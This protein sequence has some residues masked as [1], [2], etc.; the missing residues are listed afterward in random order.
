MVRVETRNLWAAGGQHEATAVVHCPVTVQE[1]R[2]LFETKARAHG[3]LTLIGACRSFGEQFL[4]PAG[5]ECVTLEHWDRQV[6]E[7]EQDADG[8]LWVRAPGHLPFHELCA[9]LPGFIPFHPPSGDRI[10]LAG[11]FAACTQDAV[12]PFASKVRAFTLLTPNGE[13]HE[14]RADAPGLA[15]ELFRLVPG[16][17]GALGAILSLELCMRRLK[18]DERAE[19]NVLECGPAA[20]YAALERLEAIF[21]SGEY[22]LGRGLFFYGRKHTSVLL[23]DR[24]RTLPS[25]DRTPRL[26]LT[27]D[28]TTRNIV[29]QAVVNRFP[30][31]A[32]RLQRLILK[33]GRRF[34]AQ[35]YGFS[36]FQRSYDRA[37]A[38][39][40]SDDPLAGLLREIGVD[41][42]LSVCHQSFVIPVQARQRF[43]DLYFEAFDGYPDLET[44]IEQQDM[45]RQP[46]CP[47]PLHASYGM[48]GGWYLF[49]AS[50]GVRRGHAERDRCSEFLATVSNRAYADLGVKVLLSKQAHCTTELLQQMHAPFVEALNT[51]K[52]RVDPQRVLC[53][54][55]L[56][57][58]LGLEPV[59]KQA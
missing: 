51:I 36:F 25:N 43:L 57:R 44:R 54:R 14:C 32:H 6:H 9:Q 55:M 4:P 42:K 3:R 13:L 12:G 18:P 58:V 59:G 38:F 29:L 26:L 56:D 21:H 8:N 49:T 30:G 22:T 16:S 19:I 11:A 53:S 27:D 23:G 47:W 48:P 50:F 2:E 41:P 33:P 46:S 1:L 20:G 28:A 40:S 34:Q 24:L 45:I 52:A 35:L 10:S 39:L 31:L 37:Y 15:G 7:I 5:A 17:F